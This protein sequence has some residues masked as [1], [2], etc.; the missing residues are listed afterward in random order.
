M[1]WRSMRVISNS[2]PCRRKRSP[3][4]GMCPRRSRISPARVALVE[5]GGKL[6]PSQAVTASTESLPG[7]RQLPS[8]RRQ[9]S[10]PTG[11]SPT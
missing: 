11:R 2:Q 9:D 7:M 8:G 5:R 4:T 10:G 1:R 6:M 3:V